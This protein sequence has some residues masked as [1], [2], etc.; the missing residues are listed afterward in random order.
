[1]SKLNADPSGCILAKG[2]GQYVV[3]INPRSE[4][5]L[6]KHREKMLAIFSFFQEQFEKIFSTSITI[7]ISQ[8][9]FTLSNISIAYREAKVKKVNY[10]ILTNLNN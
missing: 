10:L 4:V 2:N 9:D 3:V 5:S 1:M 8:P 6:Q 7:G